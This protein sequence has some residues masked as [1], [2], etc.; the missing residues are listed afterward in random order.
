[1]ELTSWDVWTLITRWVL[2]VSICAAI[3]GVCS[4]QL[5]KADGLL[6]KP[7]LQYSLAFSL[8]GVIA[9]LSH[10]FVRVG[11]VLEEGT[12]GMFEPDMV[13]IMWESAVG[14]ALML[15]VWGYALLLIALVMHLR[16][17]GYLKELLALVGIGLLAFS[18]AKA[19]HGVEQSL[20]FQWVLA[21]HIVLTAWWMGSLYPLWLICRRMEYASAHEVLE[22]FGQLAVG[23]V[24]VLFSCG[25]F[26]S[27][28]LTGWNGLLSSEYGTLLLIK[29]ALVG[30]ILV[31]AAVHKFYLVPQ[32]LVSKDS[33][34]LK[35]S[36]MLE[37]L[38][39]LSI[40]AI[41]TVI[42]T[43]VGPVH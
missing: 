15:R 25:L 39:G 27:Y 19:G 22:R 8:I 38:G 18:F 33:N 42:T 17:R 31:F 10:F 26:L 1:M 28:K 24:L 12:A 2:Y 6:K 41:T 35:R 4:L 20:F 9:G 16:P 11:A 30:L 43:L 34:Q 23:A 40:L 32:L 7:L 21:L 5:V 3:G 13:S 37:K 14:D 36:I 29:V